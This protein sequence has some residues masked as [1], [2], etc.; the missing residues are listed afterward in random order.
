MPDLRL[1]GLVQDS[2]VDGPGLRMTLFCQGCPHRCKG[3]HNPKTHPLNA[4][5]LYSLEE[6]KAMYASNALLDGITF[7]GGEP[8]LQC[9]P[10]A[11]LAA[12]V[13]AQ[14]GNV[15]LYSGY[16]LEIIRERAE[17]DPFLQRLLDHT[18]MLIDGPFCLPLKSLALPYR[19]SSNQRLIALSPQGETLIQSIPNSR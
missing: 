16:T 13:K 4:G 14:G 3:C 17:K 18:D 10:L 5:K 2:F 7:S 15:L 12:F 1:A 9:E 11:E 19:G 6:L 8:L